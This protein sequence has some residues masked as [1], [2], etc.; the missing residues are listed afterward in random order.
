VDFGSTGIKIESDIRHV[1]NSTASLRSPYVTQSGVWVGPRLLISA[2]HMQNW[3]K[4]DSPSDEECELLSQQKVRYQVE[5]EIS[6]E[7]LSGDSA[8]VELIKFDVKSDLGIF[9]LVD[10]YAPRQSWVEIDNLMERDDSHNLLVKGDVVGCIGFNGDIKS[11][12]ISLVQTAINSEI[13]KNDIHVQ[14]PV[15]LTCCIIRQ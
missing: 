6:T 3:N 9:R 10:E 12:D 14:N 5:N 1:I 8:L 11:D 15:S 4:V 2:L 13:S 7:C